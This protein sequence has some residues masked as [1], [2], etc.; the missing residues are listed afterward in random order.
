VARR[1]YVDAPISNLYVNGKK[2]DLAFEQPAAS[3]PSKRHHVRFWRLDQLAA[4]G[5]PIWIGAATYD[6]R[7]GLSHGN[8]HF[9]HHIAADVDSERDKLLGDV[10]HAGRVTIT[11]IDNFQS[12]REGRNGGGDPFHTDGRLVLITA[13]KSSSLR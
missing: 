6:A 7:I 3:N 4:S 5:R 11:W 9:T 2:Q 13:E 12:I 10:Q 1:P 8:R